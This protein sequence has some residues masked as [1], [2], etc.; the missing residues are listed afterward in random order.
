MLNQN[1]KMKTVYFDGKCGLCSKEIRYYQKIAPKGVFVWQDIAH[2]P[3]AL[4]PLGIVQADALLYLHA[5]DTDGRIFIGVDA[6]ILIWAQLSFGWRLAS[7]M[8]R[9][10]IVHPLLNLAYKAFAHYRFSRL[11]HCQIA[12][13]RTG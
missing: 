5:R 4:R 2:D 6:F 3:Q 7:W 13:G 8:A 9:L 11:S 10:P 12:A 1:T